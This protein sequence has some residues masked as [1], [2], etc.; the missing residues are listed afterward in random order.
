MCSKIVCSVLLKTDADQ[1]VPNVFNGGGGAAAAAAAAAGG[2]VAGGFL[3]ASHAAAAAEHA[4]KD[5]AAAADAAALRNMSCEG[6]ARV[7]RATLS[8][9]QDETARRSPRAEEVCQGG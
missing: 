4:A 1:P 9:T 5:A 7:V 3:T 2:G 6:R 8:A